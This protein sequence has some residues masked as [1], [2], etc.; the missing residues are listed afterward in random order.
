MSWKKEMKKQIKDAT[1]MR[2]IPADLRNIANEL[3]KND[4][5][6]AMVFKKR[7][8]KYYNILLRAEMTQAF[9]IYMLKNF[10]P[11]H[12]TNLKIKKS[13]I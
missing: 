2:A 13:L 5:K 1:R 8:N 12:L 6:F 3:L 7:D 4:I 9:K 11:I 10:D